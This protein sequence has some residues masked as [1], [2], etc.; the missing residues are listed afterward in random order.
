[1]FATHQSTTSPVLK[2]CAL[3]T[4]SRLKPAGTSLAGMAKFL[5]VLRRFISPSGETR[6]VQ[7]TKRSAHA[8]NAKLD[9]IMRVNA[10][11]ERGTA[12]VDMTANKPVRLLWTSS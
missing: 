4:T 2:Q 9:K 7:R 11:F 5:L 8:A 12:L 6:T 3:H 10:V 1:M